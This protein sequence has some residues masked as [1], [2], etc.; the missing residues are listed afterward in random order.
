MGNK[1]TRKKASLKIFLSIILFIIPSIISG[2]ENYTLTDIAGVEEENTSGIE[3]MAA[4]VENTT[5]YNGRAQNLIY[6]YQMQNNPDGSKKMMVTARG[7]FPM[8]FLVDTKEGAV[9]YLMAD[10]T[11]KKFTL[12][13]EEKEK[14]FAN[15]QLSIFNSQYKTYMQKRLRIL[16]QAVRWQQP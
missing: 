2:E 13:P 5:E 8:Q 7:L 11:T 14:L 10:G 6:D 15:Y 16:Y 1:N 4:T 9:T 12:T 3:T